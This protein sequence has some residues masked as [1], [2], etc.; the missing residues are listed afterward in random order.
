MADFIF[1]FD[2]EKIFLH[3][4]AGSPDIFTFIAV[5]VISGALAYFRVPDKV[6]LPMLALFGVLFALWVGAGLYVLTILIVGLITFKA[7]AKIVT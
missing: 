3:L 4:F 5:I 7:I 6:Y 1:P 2:F